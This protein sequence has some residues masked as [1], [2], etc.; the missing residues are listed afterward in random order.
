MPEITVLMTTARGDHTLI[1]MPNIHIFELPLETLK[2]QTFKDFEFIVVDSLYEKRKN[3]FKKVDLPF[4]VK[5]VPPKSSP[6]IDRGMCHIANDWN[7]GI[8][9]AEGEL[10][11][12]MDDWTKPAV[13]STGVYDGHQVTYSDFNSNY[14]AKIWSWYKKNCWTISL[15]LFYQNVTAETIPQLY[16]KHYKK[17][18]GEPPDGESIDRKLKVLD[19]IYQDAKVKDYR[20]DMLKGSEATHVEPGA[21]GGLCAIPLKPLLDVNGLDELFD[22]C[23]TLEDTDLGYRLDFAGYHNRFIMDKQ[24]VVIEYNATHTTPPTLYSSDFKSN[25]ALSLMNF[26]WRRWRANTT[27]LTEEQIEYVRKETVERVGKPFT[28][29]REKLFNFW[30]NH[31]PNFN[32]R[33]MRKRIAY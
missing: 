28:E 11:V 31:Q 15:S 14:L 5:H 8:I 18:F 7:T 17:L 16:Q 26:N 24:L 25:V 3:Y 21:F 19:I 4:P 22:G 6:W 9:H 27:P 10:I 1:G 13:F 12:R 33:E 2:R 29:E 23:K 30:V 32:L 20:Y